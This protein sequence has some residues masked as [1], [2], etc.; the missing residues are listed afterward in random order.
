MESIFKLINNI[1]YNWS[2]DEAKKNIMRTHTT[3][4]YYFYFKLNF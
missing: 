2:I 4:V 3:A 1:K